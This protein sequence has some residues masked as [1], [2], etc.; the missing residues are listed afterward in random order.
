[1]S[2]Q[3]ISLE[4]L[5]GLKTLTGVDFD[6][7]NKEPEN[8][9]RFILDGITY[10]ATEDPDDGYRSAL[11]DIRSSSIAISNMF[12]PIRV[13]ARLSKEHDILELVD[14]GSTKVIMEVGTD[15]SDNYYP[16]F[17][18]AFHPENMA[19]NAQTDKQA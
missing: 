11:G 13:L 2:T 10:C 4:T 7:D 6:P 16:S 19:I 12:P 8:C 1:M 3:S 14:L 15:C 18:A 5:V 9:I 17:V